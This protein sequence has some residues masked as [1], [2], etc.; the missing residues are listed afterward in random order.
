MSDM[1]DPADIALEAA[2][3]R[4]TGDRYTHIEAAARVMY[5]LGLGEKL[6]PALVAAMTGWTRH[7]ARRLLMRM[8]RVAPIYP[9]GGKW[10]MCRG[11]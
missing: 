7:D 11:P 8:S 1:D 10:Q 9:D 6:T 4:T 5:H 3:L 2:Q